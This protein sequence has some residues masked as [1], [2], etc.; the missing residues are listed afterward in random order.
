MPSA[1]PQLNASS[2][3]HFLT[4]RLAEAAVREEAKR[5]ANEFQCQTSVGVVPITVAALITPK[6]LS[7]HWDIPD[8]ATHVIL[9]GFLEDNLEAAGDL[10][11][12]LLGLI[13]ETAAEVHC[14]P[15]DCRDLHAWITGKQQ[16]VDLSAHSIEIIAEINHA[17]RSSVAEVVAIANRLRDDGADRIDLGCDPSRRC[18]KIADY[19]AALIDA[20]HELSIDT[21]D[22]DEAHDA[23]QAGAS[24]VLSVNGTNREQARD[25]DCEV[26]AIPDVPDDL[27]S[28]DPTLEYLTR[29]SIP[30]RIDP[31]LEPIGS[32]FTTSLL[33]YI[34]TRRRYPDAEMMMGIGNLTEL[35]D[36]DS[37]GVNFLL[38]GICQE[39]NIGSVLTTQVI[40][41]A[42]SSVR[43][44]DIARR[45][46]HH[47][48]SRGVP[49][50]RL[51]DELVSLRDPKL[52]PHSQAAIE[53]L[54]EGVKDNNYRLIAQDETIHLI[55]AGLHLT[56]QDPFELFAEL[57]Q[58]PQSDN[59]D[60][61]HAFYLGYEMAKASMALTLSK[62]Y[63]QDQALRWG[64]LTVEEDTHR[65]QRSS[66]HRKRTEG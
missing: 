49:P 46:V 30:F 2:H 53:A 13:H 61:S 32:G 24:L 8:A 40:N 22:P 42:R 5:I 17:P 4:G 43:E 35:T 63:E 34:E 38:L 47:A 23:I 50:K 12:P 45:L 55:S 51:S 44:C 52:R 48:V 19:V 37:A 64:H 21:F 3:V 9:P 14:G 66:R 65:L 11:A 16:V 28:L 62:Q 60:A 41:W 29:H 7:R 10:A 57:M 1:P 25:W 15:K 39:L 36:V 54:A 59:V 58:Q 27:A 31:I 26:V 56:G 18:L 33:R 20:G 6:W